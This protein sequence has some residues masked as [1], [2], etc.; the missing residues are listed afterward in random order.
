M[1]IATGFIKSDWRGILP[2][3]YV[4]LYIVCGMGARDLKKHEFPLNSRVE[5]IR[6]FLVYYT[7]ISETFFHK[8]YD[9]FV[10]LL[11]IVIFLT[12][13]YVYTM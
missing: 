9:L 13:Q 12:E 7:G 3:A 6:R 10:M 4:V 2:R 8:R 5:F 11:F 1:I